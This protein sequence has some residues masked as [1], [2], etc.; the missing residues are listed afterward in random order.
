MTKRLV[1]LLLALG[2]PG[3]GLSAQ[4]AA[5]EGPP[6]YTPVTLCGISIRHQKANP[7]YVSLDADFVNAT[8]HGVILFDKH[9]AG[10]GLTNRFREDWA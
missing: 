4:S 2:A 1:L 5:L 6:R 3:M 9:C 8:P 10:R 7:K